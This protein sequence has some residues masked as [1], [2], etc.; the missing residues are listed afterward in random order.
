VF[1]KP[2]REVVRHSDVEVSRT[3]GEH[4]HPIRFAHDASALGD[5]ARRPSWGATADSSP[6]SAKRPGSHPSARK[7]GARRGPR[8]G[9]RSAQFV[10][11]VAAAG[12]RAA[13]SKE[14]TPPRPEDFS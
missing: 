9:M 5:I 11:Q 6:P 7:S 3:A 12:A 1:C 2:A 4:V 13:H 10:A 8:L 14:K